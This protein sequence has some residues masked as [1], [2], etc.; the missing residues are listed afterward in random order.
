[1]QNPR[2]LKPKSRKETSTNT[3]HTCL[4]SLLSRSVSVGEYKSPQ[5]ME[6]S[7][8]TSSFKVLIYISLITFLS[9]FCFYVRN[10]MTC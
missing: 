9:S 10:H 4:L 1:M 3:T 8:A 2:L 7:P 5:T 6:E